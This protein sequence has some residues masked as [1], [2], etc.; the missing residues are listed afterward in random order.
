MTR[1]AIT[2][3]TATHGLI[4]VPL[5]APF[6]KN[7]M[8][9]AVVPAA[10]APAIPNTWVPTGPVAFDVVRRGDDA[11]TL[12]VGLTGADEAWPESNPCWQGYTADGQVAAGVIHIRV[13]AYRSASASEGP[14]VCPDESPDE[15]SVGRGPRTIEVLIDQPLPPGATV[16]DEAAGRTDV[17]FIDIAPPVPTLPDGWRLDH[18]PPTCGPRSMTVRWNGEAT[19]PS[20]LREV[21]DVRVSDQPVEL[22]GQLDDLVL[23][24]G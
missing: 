3:G 18:D 4:E 21:G 20:G 14:C 1:T 11:N 10:L 17:P 5:D 19:P 12:V 23:T 16:V 9:E 8:A 24:I 22:R 6:P 13:T 2:P 7:G 15:C